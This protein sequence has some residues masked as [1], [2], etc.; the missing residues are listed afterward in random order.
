M[1]DASD[2]LWR[3]RDAHCGAVLHTAELKHVIAPGITVDVCP[4]CG[5]PVKGMDEPE[6]VAE[7]GPTPAP[8]VSFASALVYPFRGGGLLALGLG[9]VLVGVV[10]YG[11]PFLYGYIVTIFVYGCACN[12]LFDVVL[13]SANGEDKPPGLPDFSDWWDDILQP[14]LLVVSTTV[15]CFLPTL[16]YFIGYL[17]HCWYEGWVP[18]PTEPACAWGVLSLSLLSLLYYP[19]ALLAAVMFNT[20]RVVDPRLVIRSIARVLRPYATVCGFMVLMTLVRVAF[21]ALVPDNLLLGHFVGVT[22]KLWGAVASMRLLGLLYR[23]HQS[24]LAWF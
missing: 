16:L 5:S 23:A 12:Y 7:T 19:M 17:W 15:L 10:A 18:D 6:P 8:P 3:C 1:S 2:P 22:L 14:I 4:R 9:T 20:T 21:R 13:T 11:L 24:T